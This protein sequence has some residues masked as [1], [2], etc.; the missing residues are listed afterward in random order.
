[1]ICCLLQLDWSRVPPYKPGVAPEIA[2]TSV[3]APRRP[4]L[5]ALIGAVL[6]IVSSFLPWFSAGSESISSWDVPV[7]FLVLRTLGD[8]EP[9]TG[10]FLM[11][12][13]VVI[14]AF[15]ISLPLPRWALLI[16]GAVATNLA[17]FAVGRVLRPDPHP[18]LGV[19]VILAITGGC[20]MAGEFLRLRSKTQ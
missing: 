4:S 8:T 7:R 13:G 5:V 15:A 12:A 17:L 3:D 9:Q 19:G 10:P 16:L 18:D 2:V 6:V 20:L 1:M 14:V 11:T